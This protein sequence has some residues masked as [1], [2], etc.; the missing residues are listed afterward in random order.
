VDSISD[1]AIYNFL[2]IFILFDNQWRC[3]TFFN[4]TFHSSVY[5]VFLFVSQKLSVNVSMW[6]DN[7]YLYI[8]KNQNGF[9]KFLKDD[10][11]GFYCY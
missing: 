5:V 6:S 4:D 3:Q 8:Q 10:I 9:L 1:D 2:G 7:N 11:A